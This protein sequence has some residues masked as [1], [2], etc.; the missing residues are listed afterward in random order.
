MDYAH[1]NGCPWDEDTCAY[2]TES[3]NLVCLVYAHSHECPWDENLFVSAYRRLEYVHRDKV[4]NIVL[5]VDFAIMNE[6]PCD[7]L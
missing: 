4:E 6:C 2:A 1:I 7:D 5:C 3:G